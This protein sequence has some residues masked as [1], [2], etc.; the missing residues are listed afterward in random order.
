MCGSVVP[1]ARPTL[2]TKLLHHEPAAHPVGRL[3]VESQ[4]AAGGDLLRL[5]HLRY[6]KRCKVDV[7]HGAHLGTQAA[8]LPAL[9]SR[10]LHQLRQSHAARTPPAAWAAASGSVPLQAIHMINQTQ[11]WLASAE[12]SADQRTCLDILL[13]A[14]MLMTSPSTC[15]SGRMSTLRQARVRSVARE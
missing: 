9:A 13:R 2:P 14:D 11:R 5:R 8:K 7:K 3:V 10:Y 12:A 1:T 4:G 15:H 6:E